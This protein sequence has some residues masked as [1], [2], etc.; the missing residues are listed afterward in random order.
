MIYRY[1]KPSCH[2]RHYVRDY[3]LAHFVIDT[4]QDVPLKPFPAKPQGGIIFFIKGFLIANNP[5]LSIT[6][7]REHALIV[8]QQEF[9]Q[10]FQLSHEFLMIDVIFQPGALY[11]LLGIPMTEFLNKHIDAELLFGQ[12]IHDVN[13]QLAN[14]ICYEKMFS[15][16][17]K[18]L[19]EKIKKVKN[20]LHPIDKIGQFILDNPTSFN[21]DFLASLA[22]LSH[23][24]FERRF[25]QQIGITPRLYQRMARFRKAF[26]LKLRHSELN[27]LDV[28]WQTGYGDYQHLVK[29]C[30]EFSG[31]TPHQLMQEQN[32]SPSG[33]LGIKLDYYR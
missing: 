23:S 8:G 18:F 26:E 15:I 3:V 19:L 12:Q 20:N 16:I 10:T 32:Y 33:M 9:R 17:E 31:N 5:S 22:C 27:W 24:Q 14:S 6:E 2:L 25:V 11:K 29:D 21:L 1:S 4:N 30:K 7:K 13:D 28:A